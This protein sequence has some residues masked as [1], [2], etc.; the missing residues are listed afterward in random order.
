MR[1]FHLTLYWMAV[2]EFILREW[3][4]ALR[5]IEAALILDPKNCHYLFLKAKIL[6]DWFS[7]P[8]GWEV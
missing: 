8:Q 7:S 2:C 4:E 1:K 5:D 3:S 6:Q